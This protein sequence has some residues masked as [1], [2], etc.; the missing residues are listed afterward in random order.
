MTVGRSVHPPLRQL[1][2]PRMTKERHMKLKASVTAAALSAV[3][4]ASPHAAAQMTLKVM[5]MPAA[6]GKIQKDI[7]QPFFE[8]LEKQ[9]G[10]PVTATYS[11][12]EATGVK[13]FDQLRVLRS[14][15]FEIV[16]LRLGQV[17]RDEPTILGM[18]LVG[19]NTDYKVARTVVDAYKPVLDARLQKQ[20]NAKLLGV[21]PF[22]PQMIF[23]KPEISGLADLKGKKVRILDGVM[24]KFMEKV[25]A[26]PVTMAFGEVS[27]GLKLGTIDCAVTGPSSAN[28]AGW[29]E[30]ATHA[31]P[32][33]LQV[34]VQGYAMNLAAWNKLSADQKSK[35]QAAF[36]N[37]EKRIWT[38]SEELWTDGL[39]CNVGQEPC[40][41]GRKYNMKLVSVKPSDLQLVKDALAEISLPAWSE[42]CDK[43]NPTCTADWKSTVGAKVG[44]K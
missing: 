30:S 19:L 33:G 43:L 6:T 26:T 25:G 3:L 5:G 12:L 24:A 8:Q 13:E 32:L 27:Q 9:V 21:W 11:T 37:L 28:S 4:F 39:R 20:F 10:F 44:I 31:Y 1:S 23:C 22:G 2:R 34:A 15:L 41:T 35:M 16:A 17:S 7:E 36:D 38:Y 40:T 18:D 42:I 29:P 14:G